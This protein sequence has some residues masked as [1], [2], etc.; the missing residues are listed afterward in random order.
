[1]QAITLD[2][3]QIAYRAGF[4]PGNDGRLNLPATQ[5]AADALCHAA[6]SLLPDWAPGSPAID[7]ILTGAGPVWG[8][9]AIAHALHGRAARLSYVAPNT[10][11]PIVIF[12]HGVQP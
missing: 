11:D 12:A 3:A 2:F 4:K 5:L 7:V 1:M 6:L 10:P 9:L 8:H